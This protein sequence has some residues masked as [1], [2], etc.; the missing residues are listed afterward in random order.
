MNKNVLI[1]GATGGIGSAI[2]KRFIEEGFEVYSLDLVNKDFGN[3]FHN[4]VCDVTSK[5]QLEEVK[6]QIKNIKF[7]HIITLAGRALEDEWK[8]F[9]LISF[10]SISNSINLN[11]AGHL[12][13]IRTFMSLFD[14]KNPTNSIILINHIKYIKYK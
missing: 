3:K 1:T 2:A 12:L 9:D 14:D 10:D 4:F 7:S 8:D 6:N 5:T 13:T 11:L